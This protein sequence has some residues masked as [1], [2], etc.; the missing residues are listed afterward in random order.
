MCEVKSNPL[1]DLR[2]IGTVARRRPYRNHGHT[3]R[4]T[5][6]HDGQV[7]GQSSTLIPEPSQTRPPTS[8]FKMKRA[9]W[10]GRARVLRR[11]GADKRPLFSPVVHA[12]DGR[13]RGKERGVT[14]RRAIQMRRA[15]RSVNNGAVN[16]HLPEVARRRISRTSYIQLQALRPMPAPTLPVS[17]EGWRSA[18]SGIEWSMYG[19]RLGETHS[20]VIAASK[21]Q[22]AKDL[23]RSLG[24]FTSTLARLHTD[25]W[26]LASLRSGLSEEV[27]QLWRTV[28]SH[29]AALIDAVCEEVETPSPFE[30]D[31]PRLPGVEKVLR[32]APAAVDDLCLAAFGVSS[33]AASTNGVIYRERILQAWHGRELELQK[34]L[35]ALLAPITEHIPSSRPMALRCAMLLVLSDYPLQAVR[36]ARALYRVIIEAADRTPE[37]AAEVLRSLYLHM[38]QSAT[39]HETIKESWRV[40]TSDSASRGAKATK[41][42]EWYRDVSE[43]QI[44]PWAWTYLA[45]KAGV[46]GRMPE[47]GEIIKRLRA[48][49]TAMSA[50]LVDSLL[51]SA[52]NAAAHA[53]F[54][55]D[56]RR[57][58]LRAGKSDL[59]AGQ[60]IIA[61]ELGLALMGGAEC[62]WSC[63]YA[64]RPRFAALCHEGV[65]SVPLADLELRARSKLATNG[66][67][68]RAFEFEDGLLSVAVDA[69]P[70]GKVNHLFQAV[71]EMSLLLWP[72]EVV[73]VRV[74]LSDV[75]IIDIGS[76]AVRATA[77]LW[78]RARRHFSS[79]PPATFLPLIAAARL[80]A[81][82]P[83]EAASAIAWLAL[84]DAL[85]ALEDPLAY[86]YPTAEPLAEA[87]AWLTLVHAALSLATPGVG[88]VSSGTAVSKTSDVLSATLNDLRSFAV[89]PTA[90][91]LTRMAQRIEAVR[92]DLRA[93]SVLPTYDPRPLGGDR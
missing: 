39:N 65:D 69:V 74:P 81:E 28:A 55:Y 18:R 4:T 92:C 9:Q 24:L 7:P 51:L 34:R 45:L 48:D 11:P 3:T 47:I 68:C 91:E 42:L 67:A 80:A 88:H 12:I 23:K 63:A 59:D 58:V 57:N 36:A 84:A 41:S 56:K 19:L 87:I 89:S 93:P 29:A 1:H 66:L 78:D 90:P 53:D 6:D 32:A 49:E 5:D 27:A 17:D 43:G 83:D 16:S 75:P 38:D 10:V 54:F 46:H 77:W 31:P 8:T 13:D 37:S 52:R 61:G 76:E 50:D 71:V 64:A 22:D 26:C 60:L 62:A 44:R 35:T 25:L 20:R 73:Q 79:I 82:E 30:G 15:A 85:S 86:S 14:I 72:V 21:A 70:E 2:E 40:I 33:S